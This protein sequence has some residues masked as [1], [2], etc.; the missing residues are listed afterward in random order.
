MPTTSPPPSLLSALLPPA[1]NAPASG[2]AAPPAIVC[3]FDDLHGCARAMLDRA[4]DALLRLF[5]RI[6]QLLLALLVVLFT[7]WCARFAGRRLHL[8]RLRSRNPY[9]DGLV[10]TVV[11]TAILL[12]GLLIALDLLGLT[13][14]VGAVLG[15]AGVVGLVLGFAFRDIAE[16][17]IAGILLSVR[18]PFE[19]GDTVNIDGREGKVISVTS[20]AT[21][22]MTFD[23]NHLQMPNSLVFKSVILNYTRNPKRRF[24]FTVAIDVSQSIRRSG[25]LAMAAI[26]GVEGVLEDPAPSWL[27]VENGSGGIVL[28]FHGWIDQRVSDLGRTRSEAIRQT[29]AAFARA[30]I[31][32]PRTIQ[33]IARLQDRHAAG[34]VEPDNNGGT[35]TS[36]NRDIDEQFA[37]ARADATGRNLLQPDAPAE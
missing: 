33:Y 17:Y 26:A 7:L 22:L 2:E 21:V 31:E 3:R 28:R 23:G 19:P 37:A 18:R 10:R 6:P 36:V 16:N 5:E 4:D 34:A 8:L 35:D 15:S 32:S 27:V 14:V 29:K 9:M 1:A 30:G 25:T 13:A 20:R 11:R 12:V 24:D